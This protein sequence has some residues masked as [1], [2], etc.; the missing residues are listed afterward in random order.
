MEKPTKNGL[1]SSCFVLDIVF[2]GTKNILQCMVFS[3]FCPVI[4]FVAKATLVPH[5]VSVLEM[6]DLQINKI[7]CER[8]LSFDM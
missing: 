8:I 7:I 5:T 1:R 3:T 2:S 6:L 4:D